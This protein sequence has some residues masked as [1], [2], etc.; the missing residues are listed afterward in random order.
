M[1]KAKFY[2]FLANQEEIAMSQV[3]NPV[4][5]L[6]DHFT[7]LND[8]R[9]TIKVVH[10]LK[11]IV[12]LCLCGTISGANGWV[13]IEAFGNASLKFLRKYFPY[14]DGIPSHDTLGDLFAVI[15]P[16]EFKVCFISWT[17]TFQDNG[18]DEIV[19]VD[20]KT[21]RGS[22]D[23]KNGKNA[24]HTVS[25]WAA[26]QR[27]VLGQQTVDSKSNEITAIPELLKLLDLK[28]TTVTIDAMGTQKKIV[29]TILA[30]NADYVLALKENQPSLHDDVELLFKEQI[31]SG[32]KDI[33]Y[34]YYENTDGG[35]GRI[36]IRKYW[37]TEDIDWLKQNH[38]WPGLVSIGMVE[39][40]RIIDDVT[41]TEIRLY[42]NSIEANA[43]RF[44]DAVRGHW[45]VENPLHWRLDVIFSDD[46]CR[47]RK[48]NSPANYLIFK[49][50]AMNLLEKT[51]AKESMNCK[52]KIAGWN[53]KFLKSVLESISK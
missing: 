48:G 7:P 30:Q 42:V 49:Q 9:Q 2:G 24:L 23:K 1:T 52:R 34:D 13:E 45:G 40:Q 10:P 27:L 12:F 5:S 38:D 8:P 20:G 19:A 35:H 50:M 3:I 33:K 53:K 29:K 11:E 18:K 36:E 4:A 37:I 46:Q 22:K 44:A 43:K 39:S 32:F 16:E 31:D 51:P 15:D 6:M 28:G 21:S 25:A 14:K 47:I 26:K 41:S 17:K